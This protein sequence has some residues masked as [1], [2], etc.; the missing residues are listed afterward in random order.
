MH[1]RM[2]SSILGLDPLDAGNTLPPS[3]DDQKYLQKFPEVP[4]G[5]KLPPVDKL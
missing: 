5:V 1:C 3:C 2:S 4:R